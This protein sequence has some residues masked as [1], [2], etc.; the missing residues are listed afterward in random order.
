VITAI[1]WIY[2]SCRY[3]QAFNGVRL[4]NADG[5]GCRFWKGGVLK[6]ARGIMEDQ[7]C[8]KGRVG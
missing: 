5:H 7:H 2:I 8:G 3:Q 1:I 4:W 6:S